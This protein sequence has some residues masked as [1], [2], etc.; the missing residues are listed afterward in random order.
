MKVYDIYWKGEKPTCHSQCYALYS[1]RITQVA[2]GSIKQ[3]YYLVA[4]GIWY[5]G[6]TGIL[7]ETH[8]EDW[9]LY[10]GESLQTTPWKHGRTVKPLP[11]K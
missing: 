8:G 2:A 11:A 6:T 10:N 4:K 9:H 1:K 5:A 3:A 7:A